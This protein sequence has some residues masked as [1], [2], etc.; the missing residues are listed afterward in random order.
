[1][2]PPG[3]EASNGVWKRRTEKKN[4]R[5]FRRGV[6]LLLRASSKEGTVGV[7]ICKFFVK[8]HLGL[9]ASM[10]PTKYTPIPVTDG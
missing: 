1:M 9:S 8:Q 6:V 4:M 5:H 7:T 3:G 2:H 10:L